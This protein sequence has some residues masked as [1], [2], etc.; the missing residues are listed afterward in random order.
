MS[1]TLG[2]TLG[3]P[4]HSLEE[5]LTLFRASGLDGAEIIWQDDYRSAIPED[6]DLKALNAIKNAATERDL[7]IG[8]LTPYVTG[9]NSE[10]DDE[11]DHEVG[12]LK[13]CIDAAEVLECPNVR[14][15]A[16][17][18][19]TDEHHARADALWA[20]LVDSVGVLGDYAAERGVT[21]CIENHFSTMTVSAA[22]TV[23]LM[24]DVNLASVG[25]LYDQGNLTFT[26]DE[27]YQEAVHLQLPWIRHVHVKDLE[28]IDPNRRLSTPSVTHIQEEDRVHR[29][30]MIGTGILDWQAIV[31]ALYAGGY[32]G[33]YSLEYEYRWN[34]GDLP[35][36]G[37]GFP[38]S[39]RR[40]KTV[41][42]TH[43]GLQTV[44]DAGGTGG[45]DS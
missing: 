38:E 4:Q 22:Q 43:A 11:R 33:P 41:L 20:R 31:A 3:T 9:I 15:Y 10:D 6:A 29:S 23:R 39:T 5:A 17:A 7:I 12:R 34:P 44:P 40:L 2:H 16:G 25:I 27:A 14:V 36:P 8:G 30:R 1:T 18:F 37:E 21:V 32:D 45:S 35:E 28:F 13:R 19:S 24:Q 26:H 42:D